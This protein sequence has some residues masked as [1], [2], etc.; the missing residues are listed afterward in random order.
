MSRFTT[1][2]IER[3]RDL[4]YQ[5]YGDKRI[6]EVLG[7]GWKSV[8]NA[9]QEHGITGRG[10]GDYPVR[11]SIGQRFGKLVVIDVL[12]GNNVLCRC[13]CGVECGRRLRLLQTGGARL[14]CGC[15][16]IHDSPIA[17]AWR[18]MRKQLCA[19]WSDFQAFQREAARLGPP[20]HEGDS[21]GPIDASKPVGP[22]NLGWREH[23]FYAQKVELLG[24]SMPAS[25]W[26]KI[27]G[28]SRQT[29]YRRIETLPV[30]QAILEYDKAR[31]WLMGRLP[32]RVVQDACKGVK[33]KTSYPW[34]LWLKKRKSIT[35]VRGKDFT[36]STAS[37]YASARNYA[38]RRGMK[39]TGTKD[40]LVV[41]LNFTK[42][43]K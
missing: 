40:D 20:P 11:R 31:I 10:Y 8:M 5:G 34:D 19:E 17:Y 37:M 1:E 12:G 2:Q 3:I 6:A 25:E 16:K 26:A 28:C 18:R 22:G 35:L 36:A 9:R 27:A 14:D 33:Q 41:K 38:M 30:A 4:Y 32:P 43:A 21:L 42:V 39:L 23:N 24:V 29:M 7:V 13:E 15:T